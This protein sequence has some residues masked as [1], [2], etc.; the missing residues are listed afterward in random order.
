LTTASSAPALLC[1]AGCRAALQAVVGNFPQTTYSA[2]GSSKKACEHAAAQKALAA[3]RAAD[4]GGPMELDSADHEPAEVATGAGSAV[5]AAKPSGD[6]AIA[7]RSG[8]VECPSA[9][10]DPSGA[11]TASTGSALNA[12]ELRKDPDL[13]LQSYLKAMDEN[14]AL[15][16]ELQAERKGRLEDR[17]AFKRSLLALATESNDDPK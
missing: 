4:C 8:D 6:A 3:L 14:Q 9:G 2:T 1:R 7:Q 16:Q 5:P 12:E 10:V 11:M 13:L 17:D 15:R